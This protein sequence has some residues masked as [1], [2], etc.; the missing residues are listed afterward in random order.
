MEP[1][2]LLL[3]PS[4]VSPRWFHFFD[5][6]PKRVH[7]HVTHLSQ[8][9]QLWTKI[10]KAQ[11][12]RFESLPFVRI[13]FFPLLFD[14]TGLQQT[15]PQPKNPSQGLNWVSQAGDLH[16]FDLH[17]CQCT[18]RIRT[19]KPFFQNLERPLR[20]LFL[21]DFQI[22]WVIHHLL[23]PQQA[24]PMT[25]VLECF[26]FLWLLDT[27]MK[28]LWGSRPETR[29]PAS[30]SI[31]DAAAAASD[32]RGPPFCFCV[33]LDHLSTGY[34][35]W[36]S[37]QHRGSRIWSP[38]IFCLLQFQPLDATLWVSAQKKQRFFS[39]YSLLV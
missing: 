24:P 26:F 4:R 38:S 27:W 22:P 11:S 30:S 14:A 17:L 20:I 29:Y 25:Y 21:W 10:K 15:V 16:I 28:P 13:H 39:L 37:D 34:I 23:R 2:P 7:I 32:G 9:N 5:F 18:V 31:C 3:R 19:S 8:V 6:H 12:F 33:L 1:R 36:S 35:D